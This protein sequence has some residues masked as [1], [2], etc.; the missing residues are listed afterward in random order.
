MKRLSSFAAASLFALASLSSSSS[1]AQKS[2]KP[3]G[4]RRPIAAPAAPVVAPDPVLSAPAPSSTDDPP[5]AT[6]VQDPPDV[7]VVGT[8]SVT[9]A[10]SVDSGGPSPVAQRLAP[11][12][13]PAEVSPQTEPSGGEYRALGGFHFITPIEAYSA[14]ANTS[15]RFAQGF[16][17]ITFQLPSP[18]T[19]SLTDGKLFLYGQQLIGQIGIV[20]RVS[21]DVRAEGAAG[22]GGNLDSILG[23]G[24]LASL[25]VGAMP[26]VRLFTLDKAA[27][28]VSFGTGAF[29][30]RNIRI[31]PTALIGKAT[32]EVQGAEGQL[33]RQAGSFNVVPA[34]M[35][36]VALGPVG[37]QTSVAPSLGVAGDQKSNGLNAGVHLGFDIRRLVSSVPVAVVAEYGLG[38]TF[39]QNGQP[40]DTAHSLGGGIYY[41]GRRDF[42]LGAIARVS[43]A[44][45][46]TT[47]QGQMVMQ[48]YF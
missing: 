22:V 25:N 37:L 29:Y 13:V 18:I 3:A 32:G 5:A 33:I 1:L 31:Q 11:K 14:F 6:T 17:L 4:K 28:Q 9:S 40:G 2:K 27:L 48:Y 16:G 8:A 34:L 38:T 24:A 45:T 41:S 10:Q 12:E 47:L 20:N 15:F 36:A 30:V 42:E 46:L 39:S 26:K 21:V 19:G 23:I 35:A 43:P 7:T 44:E